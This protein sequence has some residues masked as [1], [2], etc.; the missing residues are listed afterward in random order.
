MAN[1]IIIIS[2]ENCEGGRISARAAEMEEAVWEGKEGSESTMRSRKQDS[3]TAL[4]VV[5]WSS[6]PRG[7][8]TSIT[9]PMVPLRAVQHSFLSGQKKDGGRKGF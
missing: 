1:V 2:R 8:F 6:A 5:T 7:L 4:V 3:Y 9:M